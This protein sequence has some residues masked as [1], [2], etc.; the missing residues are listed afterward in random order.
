M[1]DK[2][3]NSSVKVLLVSELK[4]GMMVTQVLEQNGPVKIRRVGMIK[5]EAMVK[6]L[7]EMGVLRVEVDDAQSFVLEQES[8][9]QSNISTDKPGITV[10]TPTATQRLMAR[11]KQASAVDRQLSQQFHRSLFMPAIDEMPSKWR[12]YGLP[13]SLLL[14]AIVIGF[15]LGFSI[16]QVPSWLSKTPQEVVSQTKGSQNS[17]AALTGH[18]NEAKEAT[19]GSNGKNQNEN[20]DKDKDNIGEIPPVLD[21]QD[22]ETAQSLTRGLNE[23]TDEA[24]E[25]TPEQMPEQ[26]L[27]AEDKS[28][29][30]IVNGIVLNEGETLLGFG[31]TDESEP[32][33]QIEEGIN[34]RAGEGAA[35]SQDLLRR[36][37]Q[38]AAEL[39]AE[40]SEQDDEQIPGFTENPY[41]SAL[42]QNNL[43]DIITDSGVLRAPA[44][45][46]GQSRNPSG[47]DRQSLQ[48]IDQLSPAILTQIP[49]MS[50][51]AHMYASNPQDRWVRVNGLRLSEGDA[52]AQDLSIVE[53]EPE[54]IIL[55]FRGTTFSMNALSDW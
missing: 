11:D 26:T 3:E 55:D 16:M 30:R 29:Q 18:L 42:E 52:I 19:P 12:L 22:T 1:P 27:R 45:P 35:S 8:T 39:E 49:A 10:K 41:E 24:A 50:F 20:E 36:V 4:P 44:R 15:G 54:R 21:S 28:N 48:R 32:T 5:S 6:G 31:A 40:G 13:Y 2:H 47:Q 25:Q 34:S 17:T 37:Q 33:N 38:A 53:I 46:V 43:D 9:E 7:T 14:G 23:A 51:S